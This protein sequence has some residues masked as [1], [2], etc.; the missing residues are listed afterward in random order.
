MFSDNFNIAPSTPIPVVQAHSPNWMRLIRWGFHPRWAK[1]D[2]MLL[3]NAKSESTA[4]KATWKKAYR[5]SRCIIPANGFYEWADKQHP[6]YFTR[7]DKKMFGFAGLIVGEGENSGAVILT[8]SAN[9]LMQPV[10]N[11]Q[12]VILRPETEDD[13]L[14]PDTSEPEELSKIIDDQLTSKEMQRMIASTEINSVKN[15]YHDLTQPRSEQQVWDDCDD[16]ELLG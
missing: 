7:K 8:S 1:N 13:W 16:D 9:S 4:T 3:I 5:E 12:P 6:Y 14:N 10:H 15:N 2:S 11:R